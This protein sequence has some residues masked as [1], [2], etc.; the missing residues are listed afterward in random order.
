MSTEIDPNE[1]GLDVSEKTL[2]AHG[3]DTTNNVSYGLHRYTL[4]VADVYARTISYAT[5]PRSHTTEIVEIGT[6]SL[7]PA[8]VDHEAINDALRAADEEPLTPAQ[9]RA[10]QECYDEAVGFTLW[11]A[12]SDGGPASPAFVVVKD[13]AYCEADPFGESWDS[14]L[15]D[16]GVTHAQLDVI[17]TAISGQMGHSW[18]RSAV[19]AEY[20]ADIVITPL[21]DGEL[22]ALADTADAEARR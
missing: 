9:Q 14:F 22:R 17:L 7:D 11:E 5:A 6:L 4:G 18:V 13:R 21:T 8:D 1:I 16:E 2:V 20:E 3:A 19:H 10:V 12:L 15:S